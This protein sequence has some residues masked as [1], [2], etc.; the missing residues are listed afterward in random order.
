MSGE[1]DPIDRLVGRAAA[2]HDD[3]LARSWSH[4]RAEQALFEEISMRTIEDQAERVVPTAARRTARRRS[5]ARL[6][7]AATA[8]VAASLGLFTVLSAGPTVDAAAAEVLRA[9]GTAAAAAEG[10]GV[11][12]EGQY[13]YTR[14]EGVSTGETDSGVSTVSWSCEG[15]IAGDG[16][17]RRT[18]TEDGGEPETTEFTPAPPVEPGGDGAAAAVSEYGFVTGLGTGTYEDLLALPTDP[19]AL[20][21][22]FE[23]ELDGY[24]GRP[25]EQEMFVLV[26]DVL[27]QPAPPALRAALFEVASRI[28]GVELV[29]QVTDQL[30]RAG[31]AV[32][33]DD[34]SGELRD[35]VVIDPVTSA[36]L[37][38]RRTL[39]AE[40]DWTDLPPGGTVSGSAV[41]SSGIVDAIGARP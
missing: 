19:D 9:A 27:R 28:P 5:P 22:H 24:D 10:P 6:A 35:E 18:C 40:V 30:G 7:V 21:A 17:G 37:A 38:E 29:G 25:R 16:S 11:L 12:G 33:M 15:W 13:W 2:V 41:A 39:R 31:V 14:T 20:Q 34:E 1:R 8:V 23:R 3:E 26:T 32:A 36:L 4:S